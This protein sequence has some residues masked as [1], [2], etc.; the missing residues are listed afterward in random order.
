MSLPSSGKLSL[1]RCGQELLRPYPH[2]LT[3]ISIAS[4]TTS[5]YGLSEFYGY[6]YTKGILL[7]YISTPG[8][9]IN[10]WSSAF[11]TP[12]VSTPIYIDRTRG[13]TFGQ[14]PSAYSPWV[15]SEK[16]FYYDVNLT[17]PV[18]NGGG[19]VYGYNSTNGASPDYQLRVDTIYSGSD[20]AN[21]ATM[22]P[23][24][25]F[26]YSASKVNVGSTNRLYVPAHYPAISG[27]V[28]YKGQECYDS[29]S[30][31]WIQNTTVAWA[32]LPNVTATHLLT[33]I[34]GS[35]VYTVA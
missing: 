20:G 14:V 21:L 12:T 8:T 32:A 24:G 31:T 7:G 35:Y 13:W 33:F 22:A 29:S 19:S 1:I 34:S 27:A 17:L 16:L 9:F 10:N 18:N 6:T 30:L 4:G 11:T 26:V 25:Y 28:P 23:F 3:D 5:P 15:V 2:S